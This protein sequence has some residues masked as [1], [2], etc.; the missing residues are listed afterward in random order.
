MCDVEQL[1]CENIWIPTWV[2]FLQDGLFCV[3]EGDSSH[4]Y[5]QGY[6]TQCSFI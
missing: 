6:I 3:T 4:I 2:N 5:V 1:D